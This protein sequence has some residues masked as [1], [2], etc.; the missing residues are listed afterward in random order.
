MT[1]TS[2]HKNHHPEPFKINIPAGA[3]VRKMFDRPTLDRVIEA[4]E[5]TLPQLAKG[6]PYDVY[7]L[8]YPAYG[9]NPLRPKAFG[10]IVSRLVKD[11]HLPL[12]VDPFYKGIKRYFLK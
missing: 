4:L 2:I 12:E 5:C 8:A 3:T 10:K 7:A 9:E 1:M 11:G 6:F